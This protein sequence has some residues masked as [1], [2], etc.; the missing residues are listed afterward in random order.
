M[1]STARM[2]SPLVQ[3]NDV[4]L[5]FSAGFVELMQVGEF[6]KRLMMCRE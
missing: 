2:N 4:R 3:E 5:N 1:K 6:G